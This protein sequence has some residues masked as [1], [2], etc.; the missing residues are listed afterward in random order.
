MSY[1]IVDDR[2]SEEKE[3]TR[4]FVVAT[5][6]FLSGWGEAAGRSLVA[7]PF[8]DADDC[9]RVETRLR[10]R[11]EMLRVRIVG[12][13]YRPH[14]HPGDHLHIYNLRDSFRYAL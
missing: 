13:A 14:L 4:G 10:L 6:R 8:S 1:T 7:V 12:P 5:D 3:K 2:T 9:A 11:D